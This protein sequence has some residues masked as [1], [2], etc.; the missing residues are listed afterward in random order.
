MMQD[1]YSKGVKLIVLIRCCE[2]N[3]LLL[4]SSVLD[5]ASLQFIKINL[6]TYHI[7]FYRVLLMSASTIYTE[8]KQREDELCNC[9]SCDDR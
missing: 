4:V 9:E 7:Y 6:A 2:L 1:L 8:M 3:L 5:F